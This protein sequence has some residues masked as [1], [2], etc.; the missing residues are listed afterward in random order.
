MAINYTEYTWQE[1]YVDA[2]IE[3][4]TGTEGHGSR[5]YIDNDGMASIGYG[6]TFNRNDNIALWT[7]A[8][9]TL[10]PAELQVLQQIDNAP[11][12]QK[13]NMA[14]TQFTRQ[15]THDE[16]QELLRQTYT[17]YEGPAKDLNLPL[18]PERVAFVSVTYNRGAGTVR[19][20]MK[21]FYQAIRDGNRAE[22]WFQIR[23]NSLGNQNPTVVNGI[24]KRRYLESQ[25]FGLYDD[26]DN[27]NPQEAASVFK[28]FQRH[29]KEIY[30]HEARF[31][32]KFD[33][34]NGTRNMITEGNNTSNYQI[35]LNSFGLQ[36]IDTINQALDS[37]KTVLLADLR[38]RYSDFAY[39]LQD[40][41][42]KAVNIYMNPSKP[43]D[44][45]P[46]L[47]DAVPYE[48]TS[49]GENDVMLGNDNNDTM[50]G[51]KGNDVLI[52]EGDDDYIDGGKGDDILIG[53]AGFDT[54]YYHVGDGSDWIEDTGENNIIIEDNDGTIQIIRTVFKTG[55]NIWTTPNGKYDL[56]IN[57]PLKIVMPDGGSIG[58]KNFQDGD[59]GIHLLDTPEN[60]VTTNTIY[61]DQN[62]DDLN[63]TLYDTSRND[64]IEG[65]DGNDTLNAF[66]GGDDVLLGGSGRDG[67]SAGAGNDIA[68]GNSGADVI[69]GG[70]GDD[71]LFG[72][73][74]GEMEDLI[75]AGETAQN[76]NEKGDLV[77][78]NDGDDFIYGSNKND[79][80]FGGKGHDLLV[81]GQENIPLKKAA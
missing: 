15:I 46:V 80:L 53:G 39:Q 32:Q 77:S 74:K 49:A 5:V 66:G 4:I 34:S 51:G 81:G 6:Y 20:K 35:V 11:S 64:W 44:T 72:E 75:T 60:P 13:T 27:I 71:Q 40:D 18:S 65:Q 33:D 63:D 30:N 7:A 36:R 23:Y 25:I 43:G 42:I 62:P 19:R 26:P 73:S 69:M 79:A 52:G 31:G 24:A 38:T 54:Y 22:A 78:G 56:T 67:I 68:E 55:A 59:F 70:T 41:A 16:A 8:G 12:S 29:R 61:G 28:M 2:I 3:L 50:I 17:K 48:T 76:I 9:I 37:G 45:T 58:I 47:L 57:S 10:T 1:N 14:F 21:D